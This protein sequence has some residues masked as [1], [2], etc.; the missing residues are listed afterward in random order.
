MKKNFLLSAAILMIGAATLP[1]TATPIPGI[2][3]AVGTNGD[4]SHVRVLVI[5]NPVTRPA[6]RE[7]NP[8]WFVGGDRGGWNYVIQLDD[9]TFQY[10][11]VPNQAHSASSPNFVPDVYPANFVTAAKALAHYNAL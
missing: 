9:D 1:E 3:E 5:Y 8:K 11:T 10:S 4:A 7:Q 6:L 2:M